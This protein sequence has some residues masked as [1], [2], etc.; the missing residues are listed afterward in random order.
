MATSIAVQCN[1]IG[2]A[3]GSLIPLIVRP[4]DVNEVTGVCDAA[5]LA[6][7][8]ERYKNALLV[9]ANPCRAHPLPAAAHCFCS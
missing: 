3:L 1:Y 2:W 6:D 9:Q 5:P 7:T 8:G 4:C